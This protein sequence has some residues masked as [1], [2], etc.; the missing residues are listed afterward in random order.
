MPDK[1]SD[2][3][4]P[5]LPVKPIKHILKN[6]YNGDVSEDACYYVRALLLEFTEILAEEAVKEFE[7]I[8][9]ERK[10]RG[11][12]KLK[13]LDKASFIDIWDS[14]FKSINVS[15]MG[16][17]GKDNKTLLCQDGAKNG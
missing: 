5:N 1:K 12:P 15:N 9:N 4:L 6:Y 2:D 11:I 8:N 14:F 10:K 16:E 17:V 13:R 7:E 3:Y